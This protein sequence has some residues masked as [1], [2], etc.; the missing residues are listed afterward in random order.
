MTSASAA[1]TIGCYI[2]RCIPS[3]HLPYAGGYA[4]LLLFFLYV[5][6][7]SHQFV[8]LYNRVPPQSLTS[9]KLSA[10]GVV[11]WGWLVAAMERRAHM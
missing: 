7:V 11:S 3:Y 8:P 4:D 6:T 2:T 10:C 9:M 1:K 5:L